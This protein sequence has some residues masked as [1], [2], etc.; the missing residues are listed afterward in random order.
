VALS[1]S[2]VMEWNIS[3][4][5]FLAAKRVLCLEAIFF[6]LCLLASAGWRRTIPIF[7]SVHWP[8]SI[9]AQSR[10][11][12]V[13]CCYRAGLLGRGPL[14]GSGV[15]T[16]A[17]PRWASFIWSHVLLP[18]WGKRWHVSHLVL[19]GVKW[20]DVSFFKGDVATRLSIR[21][22]IAVLGPGSFS[23]SL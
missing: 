2:C 15:S 22:A 18:S 12:R 17:Q 8:S 23:H 21:E 5:I 6:I 13:C 20:V 14:G 10:R 11:T 7:Y 16:L 19:R 9:R 4:A 3:L 1:V